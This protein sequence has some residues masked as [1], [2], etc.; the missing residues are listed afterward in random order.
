MFLELFTRQSGDISK[1][2]KA[3]R[4]TLRQGDPLLRKETHNK[5]TKEIKYKIYGL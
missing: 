4:L 3:I 5:C 2:L 1:Q